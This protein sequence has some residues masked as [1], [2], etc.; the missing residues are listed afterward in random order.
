M[1]LV[2]LITTDCP[3][4]LQGACASEAPIL[5]D[6]ERGQVRPGKRYAGVECYEAANYERIG[7]GAF[8]VGAEVDG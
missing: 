6:F 2:D 3:L 5:L 8:R 7:D 1:R 4:E